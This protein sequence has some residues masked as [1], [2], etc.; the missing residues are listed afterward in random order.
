MHD[1]IFQNRRNLGSIS[2]RDYAIE[3]GVKDKNFLPKMTDSVYGW[4]VR[5]DLMEGL[6]KGIRNVPAF[7]INNEIFEGNPNY[8]ELSKAIDQL[9]RERPKLRA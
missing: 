2:L 8:N 3:A 1:L 9:L 7:L 5:N 6:H 4:T